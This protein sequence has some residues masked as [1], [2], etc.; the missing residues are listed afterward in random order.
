MTTLPYTHLPTPGDSGFLGK[1]AKLFSFA[2][3]RRLSEKFRNELNVRRAM[4]E[5]EKLDDRYLA[6]IG[7]DRADIERI[8]RGR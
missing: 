7:V 3:A 5:L 8:V 4:G 1:T 6:D 2:W